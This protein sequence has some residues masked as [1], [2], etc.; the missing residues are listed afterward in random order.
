MA[1]KKSSV[2]KFV[3]GAS[4]A[5]AVT[6]GVIA[7]LTQTKHGKK[8]TAK[9]GKQMAEITKDLTARAEKAKNLTKKK[10][11]EMVDDLIEEYKKKKKLTADAAQDLGKE[12]KKEWT[13]ISRELKK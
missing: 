6:G 13:R 1:K 10:Y 11:D 12:L 9:A 7:F 5:A 2:S 3:V 8:L 4:V